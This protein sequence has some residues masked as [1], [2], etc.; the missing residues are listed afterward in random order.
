MKTKGDLEATSVTK[1]WS[2]PESDKASWRC[3]TTLC[4]TA[5]TSV[6]KA[7]T[8]S[9]QVGVWNGS[10]PIQLWPYTFNTENEVL[11]IT[12]KSHIS[13]ATPKIVV[14][15]YGINVQNKKPCVWEPV[16]PPTPS[17]GRKVGLM[18]LTFLC[19]VSRKMKWD[20]GDS[21]PILVATT[22]IYA[23]SWV[24]SPFGLF[25]TKQRWYATVLSPAVLAEIKGELI[26]TYSSKSIWGSTWL[27]QPPCNFNPALIY[28]VYSIPFIYSIRIGRE[29][30]TSWSCAV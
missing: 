12:N 4:R 11:L 3:L 6:A 30:G 18:D 21:R 27:L 16:S 17:T 15:Q 28:P 24:A 1:V 14:L 9:S 29:R 23:F 25:I 13:N 7:K 26:R 19:R 20:F 2:L 22:V 5:V 8:K 10:C